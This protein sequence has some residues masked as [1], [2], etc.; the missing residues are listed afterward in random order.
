MGKWAE[1]LKKNVQEYEVAVTNPLFTPIFDLIGRLAETK[2]VIEW[3]FGTGYSSIFLANKGFNV[4]SYDI[5]PECVVFAK[6]AAKAKLISGS[7][8]KFIDNVNA[9]PSKAD[10]VFSQGLLEHFPDDQIVA[11]LMEQAMFGRYTIFSVPSDQYP[12]SDFGDE[13]LMTL[14]QWEDILSPVFGD[15]L[16]GLYYYG[17]NLH[18]M[19]VIKNG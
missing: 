8:L 7:V 17:Q 13:R 12:W 11:I 10:V 3:G 1:W 5:D 2:T 6:E 14:K 4:V 16:E 15:K 19:G 9:M 18:L